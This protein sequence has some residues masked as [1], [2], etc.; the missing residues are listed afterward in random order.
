MTRARPLRLRS[1]LRASVE[2]RCRREKKEE[3][4][5]ENGH[6]AG[7]ATVA[8]P[9]FD[10]FVAFAEGWYQ[11]DDNSARR[12]ASPSKK[13]RFIQSDSERRSE[14]LRV[15]R[16]RITLKTKT[17]FPYRVRYVDATSLID[18]CS[19]LHLRAT[20]C[21]YSIDL[22]TM[23]LIGNARHAYRDD[24]RIVFLRFILSISQHLYCMVCE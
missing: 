12:A 18:R 11:S 9:P 24:M 6:A 19:I 2:E 3:K 15:S 7:W 23:F 10:A 22:E 16:A 17:V 20:W 14:K 8:S 21:N 4:K 5:K 1:L 13:S